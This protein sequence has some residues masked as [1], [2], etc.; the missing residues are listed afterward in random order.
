MK[1][2][3]E[4]QILCAEEF[5]DFFEELIASKDELIAKSKKSKKKF[6]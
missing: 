3:Q 2:Y 5:L 6:D 1:S 4:I